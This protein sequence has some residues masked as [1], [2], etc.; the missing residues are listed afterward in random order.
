MGAE[1]IAN[2]ATGVALDTPIVALGAQYSV[3]DIL[4]FTIAG[5]DFD[6]VNSVPAVAFADVG[7]ASTMTVGLISTS[8]N[9]LTYR[10]TAATG[11]HSNLTGD[12]LTLSGVKMTTA[13]AVAASTVS[14]TFS[15]E[16]STGIAIDSATTNTKVIQKAVSQY[17]VKVTTAANAEVKVGTLRTQFGTTAAPVYADD[18]IVTY[19]DYTP[20]AGEAWIAGLALQGAAPSATAT[21][22]KGDFNFL[23]TNADGKITATDKITT[24]FAQAAASTATA[25]TAKVDSVA[26]AGPA[27]F[28]ASG[29]TITAGN[30][31][32]DTTITS[33]AF[34]VDTSAT[35]APKSGAVAKATNSLSAGA[36]G[37]DGSSDDIAFLP[38]SDEYAQSITVTNNGKVVGDISVV[39][40]AN[41]TEYKTTLVAPAAADSVTNISTEV[42]QFAK[43]SGINGNAGLNIIVNAPAANIQ[44]EGIYFHKATQDRVRTH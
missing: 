20:A 9:V 25:I 43:A 13:S 36:W 16:T 11:D 37:L 30:A 27:G 40:F 33:Q 6:L 1:F 8:A 14:V 24:P 10:V 28:G 18:V 2:E 17:L 5:A 29:L 39:L 23:D 15:A 19:S 31:A 41:G 35:Y 44:V 32:G 7:A 34:T 12:T 4:K 22:L 26:F 42:A 38:F 21:T 3:G